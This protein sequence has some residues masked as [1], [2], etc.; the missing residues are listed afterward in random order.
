M[1]TLHPHRAYNITKRA[2]NEIDPIG[3]LALGAPPDEYTPEI[4]DIAEPVLNDRLTLDAVRGVFWHWFAMHV[5]RPIIRQ[6][7]ELIT[8]ELS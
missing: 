3:L 4:R 8:R 2:V 6:I 5:P 1:T 7:I